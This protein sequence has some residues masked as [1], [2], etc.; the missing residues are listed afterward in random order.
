M[1]SKALWHWFVGDTGK[2]AFQ[3]KTYMSQLIWKWYL[4]HMRTA[5]AQATAHP[6]SCQ[7]QCCLHPQLGTGGSFRQRARDLTPL[8]GWACAFE[9][10]PILRYLFIWDG[11]YELQ[12]DKTNRI[13]VCPAKTKIS[14]GIHPVWSES[15]LSTSRNLGP[16]ATHWTHCLDSDQTGQ[17]PRLIWVLVGL[18][19][20]L[21]VFMSQ[22]VYAYF[23]ISGKICHI[24][25]LW[26]Q[27]NCFHFQMLCPVNCWLFFWC[28]VIWYQPGC[29]II[30]YHTH[31]VKPI[32]K[33][34]LKFTFWNTTDYN[35]LFQ[36]HFLCMLLCYESPS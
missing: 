13:S 5:K 35:P 34:Y 11:S 19:L 18:T 28:D 32:T 21:L 2:E 15:L 25:D 36:K 33:K 20:I 16:L 29:H 4:S 30:V 12:H 26:A 31:I 9:K 27:I 24:P 1:A 23:L 7:C 3:S 10:S 22:F 17:M 6:Q 14:L 8:D